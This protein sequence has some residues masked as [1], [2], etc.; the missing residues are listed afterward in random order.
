MERGGGGGEQ[1]HMFS[2]EK[3]AIQIQVVLEIHAASLTG[4]ETE[5]V[6]YFPRLAFTGSQFC[7]YQNGV[8]KI[9]S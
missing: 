7:P 1:G 2:H 9:S 5:V 8:L 3:T 4:R 6:R